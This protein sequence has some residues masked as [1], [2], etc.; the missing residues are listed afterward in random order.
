MKYSQLLRRAAVLIEEHETE[1]ACHA[2]R[3][4]L[5]EAQYPGAHKDFSLKFWDD[6]ENGLNKDYN[7][8]MEEFQ[9]YRPH[10]AD[11]D[12]PWWPCGLPSVR[13]LRSTTL[14]VL[15]EWFECYDPFDRI[16]TVLEGKEQLKPLQVILIDKAV[17]DVDPKSVTV[18][19]RPLSSSATELAAKVEGGDIDVIYILPSGCTGWRLYTDRPVVFKNESKLDKA[20]CIQ[21][22]MRVM[23]RS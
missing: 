3:M 9:R 15:A 22:S 7:A 4:V 2:I 11:T 21:A 14:I 5:Y 12:G 23:Q 19:A 17:P 16:V 6:C 10:H 8:I 13:L 18:G 20:H 1:F